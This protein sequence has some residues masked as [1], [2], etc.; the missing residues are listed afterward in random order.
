M[1]VVVNLIKSVFVYLFM[2]MFGIEIIFLIASIISYNSSLKENLVEINKKTLYY[3][4]NINEKFLSVLDSEYSNIKSDLLLIAKHLFPMHLTLSNKNSDYYFRFSLNSSMM[5]TLESND[6]FRYYSNDSSAKISQLEN[7]YQYKLNKINLTNPQI[8]KNETMLM[9]ELLNDND[10]NNISVYS[11]TSLT[12]KA[13]YNNLKIYM[14]YLITIL[15]SIMVRNSLYERFYTSYLKFHIILNDE[16]LFEYPANDLNKA[17]AMNKLNFINNP[18]GKRCEIETLASCV[19]PLSTIGQQTTIS[20][21]NYDIIKFDPIKISG[22][23]SLISRACIKINFLSLDVINEKSF[24]CIEFNLEVILDQISQ[25][26]RRNSNILKN[27]YVVFNLFGIQN[28]TTTK[29]MITPLYYHS[30]SSYSNLKNIYNNTPIELHHGLTVALGLN[31]TNSDDVFYINKN[32]ET[33]KNNIYTNISLK[34]SP[35]EMNNNKTN[36]TATTTNKTINMPKNVANQDISLYYKNELG[37][38]REDNITLTISAMDFNMYPY[39]LKT[40][41]LDTDMQLV[42]P[43]SAGPMFYSLVSTLYGVFTYFF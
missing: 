3:H 33:I 19:S 30:I 29:S 1:I 15:K 40:Y 2:F 34:T 41:M 5:K 26:S 23:D 13:Y 21:D 37:K 22:D 7:L 38:I 11:S 39:D 18:S 17:T 35:S 10:F 24:A 6:P 16:S 25:A 36:T 27:R 9:E 43:N 42:T 20:K 28:D 32:L 14:N 8:L 31:K 4:K 12:Q